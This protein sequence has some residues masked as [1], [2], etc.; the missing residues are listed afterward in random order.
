MRKCLI[1]QCGKHL[2][3]HA[4]KRI[5]DNSCQGCI[6]KQTALLMMAG[7]GK[8][9]SLLIQIGKD[10]SYIRAGHSL[11][12][13]SFSAWLTLLSTSTHSP[14]RNAFRAFVFRSMKYHPSWRLLH[15]RLTISHET[16]IVSSLDWIEQLLPVRITAA[17]CSATVPVYIFLS[18]YPAGSLFYSFFIH[19]PKGARIVI[20]TDSVLARSCFDVSVLDFFRLQLTAFSTSWDHLLQ[21]PAFLS[22]LF[23]CFS[24]TAVVY[25]II[26]YLHFDVKVC[27]W[28]K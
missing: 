19:E 13:K 8:I 1:C 15:G 26:D 9:I 14:T 6:W 20:R 10:F 18:L 17:L 4:T 11:R 3:H 24:K 23:L 22:L 7:G 16:N 12:L 28:L 27:S 21:T 25:V 5:H 2:S